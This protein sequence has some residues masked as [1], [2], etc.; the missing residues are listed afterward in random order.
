MYIPLVLTLDSARHAIESHGLL[1]A[2]VPP[3]RLP[4]LGIQ[5]TWPCPLSYGQSIRFALVL[6]LASFLA[7]ALARQRFFHAFS[8]SGLQVKRVP[9]HFL[10]DVLGLH[11]ALESA[12][13]I[14]E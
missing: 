12:K 13:R 3:A 4:Q 5:K 11:L 8:L 10:D 1:T 14:L 7:A 6:L 2:A 9:F